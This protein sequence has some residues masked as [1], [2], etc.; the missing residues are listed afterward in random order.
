MLLSDSD[1]THVCFTDFQYYRSSMRDELNQSTDRTS[2]K[3]FQMNYD[4]TTTTDSF[5]YL[6]DRN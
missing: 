1:K 3:V 5:D 6:I 4:I 2:M